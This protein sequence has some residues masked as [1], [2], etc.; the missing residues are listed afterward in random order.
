M[1]EVKRLKE[2]VIKL[3]GKEKVRPSQDNRDSVVKKLEKGSNIT[4]STLQQDQ[5]SIKHKISRKKS[6]GHIKCYR[7]LEKGHYARNCQIKS[8]E[9]ERLSRS[10]RKLPENRVCFGCRKKGHM[11]QCCPQQFRSDQNGQTG[12]GQSCCR[13]RQE[14]HKAH[15]STQEYL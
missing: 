11:T 12:P 4:R 5:K 1:N 14:A 10:Q 8:D 13:T 15:S 3:E 6:L 2:Q 7:C 9:E